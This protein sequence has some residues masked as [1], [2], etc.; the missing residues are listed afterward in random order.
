MKIYIIGPVGSG[1]STLSKV[2]AKKYNTEY[3]E[4][5][6]IIW[7]DDIGIKRPK[8]ET[9]KLFNNIINKE[10]WII[11]DVGRPIFESYYEKCDYIYY[12]KLPKFILYSR[13]IKRFVK[14]KF[15]IEHS[16]YKPTFSSLIQTIKW[17]NS[18]L[19]KEKEQLNNLKKYSQKLI[20][21]TLKDINKIGKN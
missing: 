19:K 21:L 1:K 16:N 13:I 14:Q 11:E 2:L 10:S 9:I 17:L 20:I 5:D 7:N 18:G 4:L 12:L 6:K 15:K 3:Y 8:E